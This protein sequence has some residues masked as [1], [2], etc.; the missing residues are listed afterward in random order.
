MKLS[1]LEPVYA[2][3]GPYTS[4]YLDTSR[5]SE[6]PEA[7]IAA[8]W[9]RLGE[10]LIR[11][12]ADR[13]S[14]SAV[15]EVVGADAEVPGLHGQAIFG[16]HG[17]L[18]MEGELPR[19]PRYD[20]ALFSVLP[21][22]M[23]LVSQY[24]PEIPYVAAVV[25]YAGPRTAGEVPVRGGGGGGVEDA[26]EGTVAVEAEAGTWPLSKVTLRTR[27]HRRCLVDQWHETAVRVG[28]ELDL[29]ARRLRADSLVI[30]GDVWASNVLARALP[31][32][33]R[34]QVERVAGP[35]TGRPGRTLLEE[36]LDELFSG[37]IAEHDMNLVEVFLARRV[38]GRGAIEGLEPVVEAL[39]RGY[40]EALL[41]NHPQAVRRL[42]VGPEAHQLAVY[43]ADLASDGVRYRSPED[44]SQA[45]LRSLVATEAELVVIP[46]DEVPLRGG[47]GAVLRP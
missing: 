47:V 13:D 9:S 43:E 17:T 3:P 5:D 40:V 28:R 12:G 25:H 2:E 31:D 36:E 23:P 39:R 34:T 30:G 4:V 44:G 42:W 24:L 29:W 14:I 27:L 46:E 1:F 45:L 8:R 18:V 32:R 10:E 41:L 35:L 11:Q 19:V 22:A 26:G 16:A 6:D 7:D 20:S 15:G 21:D 37:R 33:T 38:Q